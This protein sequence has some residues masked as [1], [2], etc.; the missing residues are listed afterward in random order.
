VRSPL[1]WACLLLAAWAFLSP[2]ASADETPASQPP[3][4][5]APTPPADAPRLQHR[6]FTKRHGFQV[7]ASG[8]YL[9]RA[10]FFT[11]PAAGLTVRYFLQE[12]WAVEVAG[13]RFFSALQDSAKAVRDRFGYE[14]DSHLPLWL[15]RGGLRYTAG[16]GK[17][18]FGTH[19]IHVEPQLFGHLGVLLAETAI[20]PALDVGAGLLIH[21]TEL[22][23]TQL[24]FALLP[25]LENRSGWVPVLGVLPSLAIGVG[26]AL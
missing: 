15:L 23:Y 10:D 22:L 7:E 18:L 25:H 16:Y 3:V 13:T 9:W 8:Q 19:V 1:R 12:N 5:L 14:P 26:W 6:L 24:D 17:L 11:N 2:L 21:W 4:W 20:D